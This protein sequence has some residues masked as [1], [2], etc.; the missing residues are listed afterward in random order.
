MGI[1]IAHIARISDIDQAD[2]KIFLCE[3]LLRISGFVFSTSE[4]VPALPGPRTRPSQTPC[5]DKA[6]VRFLFSFVSSI[7]FQTLPAMPE[8]CLYHTAVFTFCTH[9][10]TQKTTVFAAKAGE[11]RR[12]GFP[13][14]DFILCC[15]AQN[16]MICSSFIFILFTKKG[17]VNG[18]ESA[19]GKAAARHRSLRHHQNFRLCCGKRGYF[20]KRPLGRNSR[21]AWRKW[22]G[23]D[24]AYEHPL[25]HLLS[26]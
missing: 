14:R 20:L 11:P 7:G 19:K 26:G 3:R 9:I 8:P 15:R 2:F 25:R 23:Q 12:C 22:L 5:K 24:D 1:G 10:F 18:L 6:T 17:Q 16:G 21:A 4:K 13:S